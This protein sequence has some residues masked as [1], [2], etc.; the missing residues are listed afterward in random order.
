MCHWQQCTIS[1]PED[2]KAISIA[3]FKYPVQQGC[4]ETEKVL[5][6]AHGS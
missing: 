1:F 4:G 5:S 3:S 2:D 6:K